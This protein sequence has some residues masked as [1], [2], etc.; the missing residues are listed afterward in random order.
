MYVELNVLVCGLARSG[1]SAAKLLIDYGATVTIY[2]LKSI[3]NINI[4]IKPLEDLGIKF[5]LGKNPDDILL[6]F[7]LIV[8]SPG[9]PYDLNFIKKAKKL[10][11]S[12]I[13]E[14]ELGFIFCP[15]NIAAITG[16]NGKSTTTA[17]VGEIFS[18]IG[19]AYILG[20]I[21][22]PF[23]EKVLSIDKD[24][25]ISLETSSFQLESTIT[26]KPKVSVILNITPDHLNR[27][28]S[29]DKYIYIKKKIFKN[30]NANDFTILNYDDKIIRN[31]SS[32]TKGKVIFFSL[33]K[34]EEGVFVDSQGY[35]CI[36][37]FGLNEIITHKSNIKV[38]IENVLA[39]VAVA[40][41]F[42][43]PVA[44]I[45]EVIENF[46]GLEH[47]MELACEKN[48]ILFYNDSKA[49]N[50]EAAIKALQSINR[51]IILIV[52]GQDKNSNYSELVKVFS[53]KVKKLFILGEVSDKIIELCK[54]YSFENYEKVNTLKDAV[55]LSYFNAERGD[56]IILSPACASFDM[57]DN[58]EQRGTLF[59][60]FCTEVI[61]QNE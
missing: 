32:E 28:K 29:M 55:E 53:S 18:F 38:I 34:L 27:H 7:D 31:M 46:Y 47:R 26:F 4:N 30:Q 36:K 23:T 52:G 8:L 13:G 37:L 1:I 57:F 21:G 11:I 60:Y 14:M 25:L 24:S 45:K 44:V 40:L 9:I 12:V 51:P 56:C 39:S 59:K 15:A 49:T 42:N 5:Y 43:I 33:T 10:G 16:T 22:V 20:N 2:D 3:D 35:I 19:K 58:Y 41:C 48:D 17:L 54:S 6:D 50:P 61:N